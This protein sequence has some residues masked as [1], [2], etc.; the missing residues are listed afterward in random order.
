MSELRSAIEQVFRRESGRI[1]AGLIRVSQSFDLAEEAMQDAFAS[2]LA[3]WENKGIPANPAAWINAVARRKL[4]DY[5]R[6]KRTQRDNQDQLLYET[7]QRAAT[8]EERL[9]ALD[10]EEMNFPD[11][12]LRLV[13]TCCHPALNSEAQIGLTLHTL[14]GLTTPEI[15][16][17]FL[18]PEAT[19]AQ[20]LV[21]AKR[22][23]KEAGIPYEV[24]AE[25]ALPERLAAVQAVV[26]LV[27]NEG[28]TATAG[29]ALVRRELCS[30]AIRLAR[31][32]CELLANEPENLGLLALML[33]HDS[34]RDARINDAGELVPLEEQNRSTWY[35][36][37][38]EEGLQLVERALRM[39]NAGPYQLQ[40]AI[41]ALHGQAKS[42]AE[43]DWKQ[44]AELYGLL[45]RRNGSPVVALNRAVAVAISDGLE[46]GLEQIRQL[47][48]SGQ[49]DSYH[50]YHAAR[51]DLLRRLG[52]NGEALAAYDRALSLTANAV[53]RRYLRRR[54]AELQS[55]V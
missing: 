14:G 21:R 2:A 45:A 7:S 53:E 6:R 16:R 44:I 34:R 18:L 52:R 17:A 8:E 29:D 40:A 28:Y 5:A 11:D 19:L 30:E 38:I 12:R 43:T 54:I 15:A 42:A 22:K 50:L 55:S 49:L 48:Q 20:R 36:A 27:F 47:G 23:I 26:Y 25:S 13:F 4:V 35:S 46:Q 24:P 37:Q 39:G 33:L 1:I 51:A 31:T 32:L 3:D 9:G 10:C 41:A